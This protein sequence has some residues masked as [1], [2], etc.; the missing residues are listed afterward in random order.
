MTEN[1]KLNSKEREG[2]E[3]CAN[4]KQGFDGQLV[5]MSNHG[6]QKIYFCPNCGSRV[7]RHGND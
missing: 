5:M 6:W 3:Y 7:T 1:E 4:G 2:C